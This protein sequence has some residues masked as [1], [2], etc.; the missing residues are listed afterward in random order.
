MTGEVQTPYT[1]K[2]YSTLAAEFI[3]ELPEK[4]PQFGNSTVK[5]LYG[6]D[7]EKYKS[8][9]QEALA[10]ETGNQRFDLMRDYPRQDTLSDK[11]WCAVPTVE[12]RD[13]SLYGCL[14]VELHE[15]LTKAEQEQLLQYIKRQYWLGWGK[16]FARQEIE[17]ADGTLFLNFGADEESQSK[18]AFVSVITEEN[19][20]EME[21]DEP[22]KK[23]EITEI[24]HPSRPKLHRIRAVGFVSKSVW[25]GAFGG[26]VES[27]DNLSQEGDCWIFDDAIACESALVSGDAVLKDQAVACGTALISNHAVVGGKAFIQDYAMILEGRVTGNA[28][29]CGNAKLTKELG[30]ECVPEVTGD[31]CVYGTVSG[32]VHCSGKAIILPGTKLLNPT[33]DLFM[34][35]G[36]KVYLQPGENRL[37]IRPKHEPKAKDIE[38]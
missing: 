34:L 30:S 3:T 37:D 25:P 16:E 21:E 17:V 22:R 36:D 11:V 18:F 12:T 7:L 9:I 20:A 32:N 28:R 10:A 4:D 24:S 38:R 26:F 23:Y 29:I 27:E 14:T 2:I 35:L 19:L 15:P 31:A 33:P 13:G 5:Y 6:E 1:L 8:Q